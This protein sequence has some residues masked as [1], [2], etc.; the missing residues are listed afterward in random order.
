MRACSEKL[1]ALGVENELYLPDTPQNHGFVNQA[2]D[3]PVAAE[4]FGKILAFMDRHTK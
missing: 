3:N 2:K 4:C 1:T